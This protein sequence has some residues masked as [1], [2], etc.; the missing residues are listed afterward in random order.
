PT[1]WQVL[2][3]VVVYDQANMR[4]TLDAFMLVFYG[5]LV[6]IPLIMFLKRPPG[7]S[8]GVTQVTHFGE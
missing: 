1:T 7:S 2:G 4:G 3:N 8:A 5:F 6:L